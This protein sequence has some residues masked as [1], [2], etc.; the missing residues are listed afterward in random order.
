[1]A[2]E[3]RRALGVDIQLR[4]NETFEKFASELAAGSYDIALAH[5]FLYVDAP[6]GARLRGDRAASI[7]NCAR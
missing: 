1:M 4:T 3:F 2:L 5:P 6:R 7:R